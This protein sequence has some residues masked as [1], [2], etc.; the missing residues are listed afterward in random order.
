MKPKST[1]RS[2]RRSRRRER[3]QRGHMNDENYIQSIFSNRSFNSERR[4]L[5]SRVV[6]HSHIQINQPPQIG[7]L[8]ITTLRNRLNTL[9]LNKERLNFNPEDI[10]QRL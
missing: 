7:D 5:S 10:S 2:N 4:M 8:S 9:R 1:R 3:Q 6:P